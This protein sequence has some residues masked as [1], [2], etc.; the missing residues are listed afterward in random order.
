MMRTK[1]S[2]LADQ[3]F[4]QKF[5]RWWIVRTVP[6]DCQ[7]PSRFYVA[8]QALGISPAYALDCIEHGMQLASPE[9]WLSNHP[10]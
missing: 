7:A 3:T 5:I 9:T 1:G 4:L 6:V 8:E 2:D 10:I